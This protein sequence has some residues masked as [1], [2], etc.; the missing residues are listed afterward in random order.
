MLRAEGRYGWDTLCPTLLG[1][2]TDF[3]GGTW[4]E[5]RWRPSHRLIPHGVA[6]EAKKGRE[7]THVNKM[8]T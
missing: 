8:G 1:V 6:Y 4:A 5:W 7:G 3:L 2:E